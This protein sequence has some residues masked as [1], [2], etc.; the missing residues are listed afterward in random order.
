MSPHSCT[1]RS[2]AWPTRGTTT[3]CTGTSLSPRSSGCRDADEQPE[4]AATGW[5]GGFDVVLGNPPWDRIKLQEKEWFSAHGRQDIA[6][7]A[8]AASASG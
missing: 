5:S 4:N 8:N 6:D 2:R 1:T 3:S 7:A